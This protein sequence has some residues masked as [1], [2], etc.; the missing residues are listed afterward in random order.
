M[1]PKNPK[2][3]KAKREKAAKAEAESKAKVRRVSYSVGVYGSM[4]WMIHAFDVWRMYVAI[5]GDGCVVCV[6]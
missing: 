2:L 1:G 6:L 3:E 4:L 5:T